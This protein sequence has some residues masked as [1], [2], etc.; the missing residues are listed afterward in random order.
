M[1]IDIFGVKIGIF[2]QSSFLYFRKKSE[3]C[4]AL[5]KQKIFFIKLI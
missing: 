5:R 1:I 2:Y 4:K 3:I